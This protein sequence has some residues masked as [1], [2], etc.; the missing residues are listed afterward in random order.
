MR[1][2]LTAALLTLIA[3][4]ATYAAPKPAIVLGDY[5]A[6]L[7]LPD[8][9]VDNE[10]LLQR[11][12]DMH[13]NTYYYLIWHRA[14]D[15]EDLQAF[16]PLAQQA[17]ISVWAYLCPPS[18]SGGTMPYSEPFR[19]DYARWGQEIGKLSLQ[20][21][22]LAGWVIDDFWSNIRP[23]VFTSDTVRAFVKAGK[24]VNPKLRFYPLMY[25]PQ[26][27]D[28]FTGMMASVVDG[29]VAAYPADTAEIERAVA[30]LDDAQ[31]LP[32][33]CWTVFPPGTVSKA[34]DFASLTQEAKVT[35]PNAATISFH[36]QDDYEGPTAGYHVMQLK[37]DDQ[38][39]WSEDVAGHDDKTVLLNLRDYIGQK[40]SVKVTLGVWDLKGV[41]EFAVRVA[42]SQLKL[43]GMQMHNTDL[44]YEP[45]WFLDS[46][47]AFYMQCRV[48]RKPQHA[49]HLPLIVMPC[50][51][52]GEYVHRYK[53]EPTPEH[54]A[55]RTREALELAKA[56]KIE[57]VVMYC[58]DKKQGNPDLDAIGKLF[59]EF[60]P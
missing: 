44:G 36:Y 37:V 7:R 15:W 56:G 47:G 20:Y 50:G 43:A 38:V 9:R 40:P 30:V 35:D 28:R 51:S 45:G 11:L 18:E 23:G 3:T 6:E 42:F 29:V 24:D 12:Q 53:D 33:A 17:G 25:Y 31:T 21:P 5:D 4:G 60:Q 1:S 41:S 13:A 49:F 27:D 39:V 26:I 14:T 8:G 54:I 19:L 16:L 52:R 2:L 32:G 55:A 22:N 58:L 59:R 48:E 34:G 57:G 46:S 10:L